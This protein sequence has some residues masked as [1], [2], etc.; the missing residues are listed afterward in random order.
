MIQTRKLQASYGANPLQFDDV[1]WP[2]GSL[3][4]LS[5]ASGS[6][7]STWLA[8]VAALKKPDSGE[9]LVADV[10]V[11]ALRGAAADA[12]RA[13][14]VGLLTQALNLND[15][16][17]VGD[18]LALAHWAAGRKADAPAVAQALESLGVGELSSRMPHTLSGGQAQRVALARA[19]LLRPSIILADEPTASL[20]DANA[21]AAITALLSARAA[22]NSTLVIA[23]HD[24]RVSTQLASLGLA[25]AELSLK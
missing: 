19:V 23:T 24:A 10:D 9:L 11:A 4:L 12:F 7:K 20:D 13:R 14:H 17:S 21:Q 25:W 22:H 2:Q 3:A 15:A 6:G 1:S 5:G 18:N 8:L 16:L